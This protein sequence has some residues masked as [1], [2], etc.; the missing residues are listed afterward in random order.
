MSLFN[1]CCLR[2]STVNLA[3]SGASTASDPSV[4]SPETTRCAEG[5]LLESAA[6]RGLPT[7]LP[8]GLRPSPAPGCPSAG[9]LGAR[10]RGDYGDVVQPSRH[11]REPSQTS[12][13]L[14]QAVHVRISL[15]SVLT[16]HTEKRQRPLKAADMGSLPRCRGRLRPSESGA[17]PE[18]TAD[19]PLRPGEQWG[20]PHIP[21]L[22]V[23]GPSQRQRDG[24]HRGGHL[25]SPTLGHLNSSTTPVFTGRPC[26]LFVRPPC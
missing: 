12:H 1:A 11:L 6:S 14:L 25:G 21:M 23:W 17:H 22:W 15:R 19:D 13:P 3:E 10:G 4:P 16:P 5:T 7:P 24:H 18:G 2:V 20:R 26:P 8:T 9:G